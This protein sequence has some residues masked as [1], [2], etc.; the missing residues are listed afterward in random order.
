MIVTNFYAAS[1]K[2]RNHINRNDSG[3]YIQSVSRVQDVFKPFNNE[4][5]YRKRLVI[6]II[7]V[8]SSNLTVMY[9]SAECFT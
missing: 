2:Q 8:C 6:E 3:D 9:L 5:F 7:S 1:A 4:R